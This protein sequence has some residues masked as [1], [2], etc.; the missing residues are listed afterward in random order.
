MTASLLPEAR[1]AHLGWRLLAFI[2]DVFPALALC[3]AFGAVVTVIAWAFGDPDVSG[4]PWMAPLLALGVWAVAGGYFVL[5]W[6]RGGQT[7]GMRPWRLRVVGAEGRP[8]RFSALAKRYAWATLPALAGLELAALIDWPQKHVPF[9]IALGLVVAGWGW[10]LVDR[11]GAP[12][13]DRL[14]GTRFVRLLGT[15]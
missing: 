15:R 8:A 1:P 9:W 6:Y 12:L 3:L 2:Y 10:A 14:S 7:L 5:S 4:L 11:D 13:H